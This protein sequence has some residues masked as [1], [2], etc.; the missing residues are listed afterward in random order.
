MNII[1]IDDNIDFLNSFKNKVKSYAKTIFDDATIDITSDISILSKKKFD[2][3]FLDIALTEIDGINIAKK[4]KK[5]NKYAKIIFVTS[6]NDLIYN[7][8]TIQPFYFIRK[9][10]LENDLST[11]FLLLKD[12][13]VEKDFYTFKY[14]SDEIKIYVENI[15]YLETNDHLTTIHTTNKQ[16]HI[17]KPLKDLINDINS[18]LLVQVNRKE[19]I[20]LMHVI[21]Q[22]KNMIFLENNVPIKLGKTYRSSFEKRFFT[23]ITEDR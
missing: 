19:C 12:F 21:Q 10:N 9:N 14:E 11:A 6:K 7:A 8:I 4:I 2:I 15:I 16:Y 18:S 5:E 3:Y 1:L 13:F 23:F 22:K 17:Y 20:N